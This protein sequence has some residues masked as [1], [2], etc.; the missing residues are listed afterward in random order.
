MSANK[1]S[2]NTFITQTGEI[3]PSINGFDITNLNQLRIVTE[4]AD[5]SNVI[6]IKVRIKGQTSFTTLISVTGSVNT[7]VDIETY[8]EIKLEC[9]TYATTGIRVK[10]VAVGFAIQKSGA[11]EYNN[12]ASFPTASG[13]G[14]FAWDSANSIMYYD[15]PSS[16]T[17][18]QITGGGGGSGNYFPETVRSITAGEITTKSITLG[19]TPTDANK[20]RFFIDG[21]PTLTYGVDF[22]VSGNVLTWNGL[23]LDGIIEE[24]DKVFVTY[25]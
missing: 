1:F 4:D 22:T 16:K 6:D 13:S 23:G 5:N 2:I 18:V 25:N 19:G 11:F 7:V 8:D 9:T 14:N 21:A 24:N 12:F 10:V 17:W 3:L 15:E 20:T